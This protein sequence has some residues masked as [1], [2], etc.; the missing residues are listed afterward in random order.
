MK[1]FFTAVLLSAVMTVS[2][3]AAVFGDGDIE[4]I[5][6]TDTEFNG[7]QS[8]PETTDEFI[9]IEPSV[10]E[11]KID[12]PSTEESIPQGWFW[13]LSVMFCI[14]AGV[15]LFTFNSR[16]ASVMQTADGRTVSASALSDEQVVCAIRDAVTA[17]PL[18][19][20]NLLAGIMQR[21]DSFEQANTGDN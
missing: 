11:F 3:S 8:V 21:I 12:L 17:S 20:D 2:A 9:G 1:V 10:G 7:E 15:I 19:S 4:V 14:M 16:T 13:A 18:P 6:G 5:G